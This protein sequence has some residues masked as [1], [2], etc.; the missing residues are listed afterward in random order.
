MSDDLEKARG[1]LQR[2][3]LA[4]EEAVARHLA[5]AEA[6]EQRQCGLEEY[7]TVL[8]GLMYAKAEVMVAEF[9][10]NALKPPAHD[11]IDSIEEPDSA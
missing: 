4:E 2:A 6:L 10:V 8:R 5:A 1:A 9:R 11:G 3:L 7:L